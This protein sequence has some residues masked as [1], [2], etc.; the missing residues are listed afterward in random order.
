MPIH[1]AESGRKAF[2]KKVSPAN[3]RKRL[4]MGLQ[5]MKGVKM[6]TAMGRTMGRFERM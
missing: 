4:M 1:A 5:G 6:R 3:V 2:V